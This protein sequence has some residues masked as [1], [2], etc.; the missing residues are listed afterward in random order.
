MNRGSSSRSPRRR[1]AAAGLAALLIA[2]PFALVEADLARGAALSSGA[3]RPADLP[4]D[5]KAAPRKTMAYGRVRLSGSTGFMGASSVV[6]LRI[7]PPGTAPAV[8]LT[9]KVGSDGRFSADFT[10][11]TQ[12]G[13]YSVQAIAPDKKGQATTSFQIVAVGVIPAEIGQTA[14]SLA[15][16][17][18]QVL[19]VVRK[20]VQALPASAERAEAEKRL[21]QLDA[22]LDQLPAQTDLLEEE[23]QKVFK[24]RAS[25]AE[26]NP[27]WDAYVEKLSGWQADA[28]G[29]IADLRAKVKVSPATQRCARLDTYNEMLTT[30]METLNFVAMPFDIGVSFLTEKVPGAFVSRLPSANTTSPEMKFAAIQT[31]K[32]SA[33]AFGGPAGLIEAIPGFI[34]EVAAY[35]VQQEFSKFCTRLEGQISGVFLGESFTQLGEPFMD[36]TILI[37]GKLVLMYDKAAPADKPIAVLGYM[38]GNG[39]FQVRDNPAPII[40][41]TPGT[42]LFHKVISPPGS[43]YFDE[44]G[45]STR[46]MLPHSFNLPVKGVLDGD[47]I[48]F[49]LQPPVH[50]FGPSIMG[51]SIYV[52]LPLAG[53]VPEIIDS[54]FPL[55]KAFPIIDRVTRGHPVLR[56]THGDETRAEGTFA[57]DTTNYGRTAR[58][59]TKLTITACDP[60]CLIKPMLQQK[61]KS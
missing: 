44:I 60:G 48:V 57:R 31:M 10:K 58:V 8:V 46:S 6:T 24:A 7:Q 22:R 56:V 36:Y 43:G 16:L 34:V 13:A 33:A 9:A 41:V 3:V 18:G 39:R 35:L 51:R 2:A 17:A 14:D 26:D 11:T 38:E 23:L 37:D 5:V 50:D 49:D 55:Q 52:V 32:L 19:D 45:Q 30:I 27:Q 28:G 25:V 4:I 47:S 20:G 15:M 61:G 53:L 12:L 42:V 21:S 59:R 1:G 40:K 29:H 54:R